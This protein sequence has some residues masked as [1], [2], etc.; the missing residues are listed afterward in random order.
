M[1]VIVVP[2]QRR[3]KIKRKDGIHVSMEIP[4]TTF[5]YHLV[6]PKN[7]EERKK[8][9]TVNHYNEHLVLEGDNLYAFKLEGRIWRLVAYFSAGIYSAV[10]FSIYEDPHLKQKIEM[11]VQLL[12]NGDGLQ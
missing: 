7:D 8:E 10:D 9:L 4:N 11:R 5:Y 2:P 1:V 12:R 6:D 3:H